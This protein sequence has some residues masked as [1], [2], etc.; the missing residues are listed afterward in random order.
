M[1]DLRSTRKS[2]IAVEGAGAPPDRVSRPGGGQRR[3]T[4]AVK[5][6]IVAQSRVS[7]AT[8]AGV[9]PRHGIRSWSLTRHGGHRCAVPDEFR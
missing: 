7:G 4:H 1:T 8:V 3:W 6:R 5:P 2:N 9:A